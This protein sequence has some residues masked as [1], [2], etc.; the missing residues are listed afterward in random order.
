MRRLSESWR[1]PGWLSLCK[2]PLKL[3]T[4]E[5]SFEGLRV[6]CEDSAC[7]DAL[8]KRTAKLTQM[9]ERTLKTEME[10]AD[11]VLPPQKRSGGKGRDP[12]K[13]L[14]DFDLSVL[15]RVV[16]RMLTKLGLRYKKRSRNALLI[17]ATHIVQ[18]SRR[19]LRQIAEL[20]R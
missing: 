1:H 16:Q 12:T 11:E 4:S 19:Y 8:T 5:P 6:E 10:D 20:R 3:W 15:R 13:K 9:S 2:M 18:S 7:G 14:D 17:E